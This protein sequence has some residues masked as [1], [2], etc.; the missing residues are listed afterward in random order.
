MTTFAIAGLQLALPSAD[1]RDRI[2]HDIAATMARFPWVQMIVL[3]ELATFGTALSRAEPLPGPT[4]QRYQALARKHGIWLVPGSLYEK[5]G[6]LVYNTAPAIDPQ[7][8]VVAR[9]RKIYPFLPYETGV[10]AGSEAVVF[11]VPEVGR[12]GLSICYDQ[13][14]PEV[15]RALAWKGAEVILH[16]TLTGTT[17]RDQELVLAQANAITNQCYF[18]DINGAGGLGNGRSIL[19]GP[20]GEVLHRA[21]ELTEVMPV[22]IDLARVRECRMNGI[23]GLGQMLKSFRD[24]PVQWPCYGGAEEASPS[25]RALGPLALP[26][27]NR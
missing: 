16:P 27:R 9:Y 12:F 2:E 19:V 13:W 21:G 4:E 6:D 5:H 8:V 24:N 11:D 25:L 26:T 17:D 18:I 20:E 22:R 3:S 10:A 7:G 23:K 14:F 15:A 1:N